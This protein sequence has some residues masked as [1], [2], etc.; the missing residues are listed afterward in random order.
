VLKFKKI[1]LS[2][3]QV[4]LFNLIK[5]NKIVVATGPAGTSKSFC[6]CYASLKLYESGFCDKIIITKPTEIVGASSLGHLPGT[7]EEKISVYMDSFISVC[8]DVI[9]SSS[10]QELILTKEIEYKPVQFMRGATFKNCVVIIDEFQSFDI[11]ELMAI[12]TRFGQPNCKMVFIGDVNQ[13]DIDKKY[14]AVNIFKEILNGI[15]SISTFEFDRKDIVR[16]PILIEITDK[17][18]K[19]KEEGKL[20]SNRKNT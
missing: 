3:K 8:S 16:D 14:V 12:V 4:E 9:E 19:M 1:K 7:L 11:K 5:D 15:S 10:L 13:S 20:T 2:D 6:A 18:E 17:Y